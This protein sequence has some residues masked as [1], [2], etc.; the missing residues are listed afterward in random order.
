MKVLYIDDDADTRYLMRELLAD[1]GKEVLRI[2]WQDASGVE[3]ALELN[4]TEP[5]DAVLVDNRLG[6]RPGVDQ[7]GRLRDRWRCPVWVVSGVPTRALEEQAVAAGA[8]GLLSKDELLAD[9][10]SL[11]QAIVRIIVR[12]KEAH[13]G[14]S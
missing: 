10:R 8:E 7:V 4:G 12:M 5:F 2:E 14:G 9:G 3:E 13:A 6:G 11:S 1:A